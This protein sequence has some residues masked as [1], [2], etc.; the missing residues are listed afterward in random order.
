MSRF[1]KKPLVTNRGFTLI[2]VLVA[3]A[4]LAVTLTI[5]F[6]SFSGGINA[7]VKSQ[8][9][10]LAILSAQSLMDRIGHDIPLKNG[11][12]EGET[13]LGLK[14]RSIIG[15]A[16][17]PSNNPRAP[18]LHAVKVEVIWK[19]RNKDRSLDLSTMKIRLTQ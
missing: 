1:N 11:S 3:T 13:E 8:K 12:K 2:E 10:I 6:Q 17:K 7:T 4:I 9:H 14:W 16:E 15:F 19:E 5:L 18:T